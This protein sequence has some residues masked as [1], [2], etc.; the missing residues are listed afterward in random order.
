MSLWSERVHQIF[1]SIS[2]TFDRTN[3]PIS[4]GSSKLKFIDNYRDRTSTPHADD[5]AI[6][7]KL[8]PSP[9]GKRLWRDCEFTN[10]LHSRHKHTWTLRVI[11]YVDPDITPCPLY[12]AANV[13]LK[14]DTN[15]FIEQISLSPTSHNS[16]PLLTATNIDVLRQQD[17]NG[18]ATTVYR[19]SALRVPDTC[20]SAFDLKLF[21]TY[22]KRIEDD[23][24][25]CLCKP[26][27][28][29]RL[30]LFDEVQKRF[31]DDDDSGDVVFAFDN[32][33]VIRA[34]KW[35][36]ETRVPYFKRLFASGMREAETQRIEIKDA[37]PD[38]FRKML[39]FVNCAQLPD[40]VET[41]AADL[42]PIADKYDIQE[43]KDV[44]A[45]VFAMN[46]ETDNV[47]MTLILADLYR[48]ADL[49]NVCFEMMTR[50]KEEV[51]EKGMEPLLQHPQLLMEFLW[52]KE[53]QPKA[54]K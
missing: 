22:R 4:I 8:E 31:D 54:G 47:A 5:V 30:K 11:W 37:D 32:D 7:V 23:P 12:L 16:D 44:C 49:K 29:Y 41:S 39:R 15:T 27:P 17:T 46:L 50:R 51:G 3:L 34:H 38:T 45:A 52:W 9:S 42:L 36:L 20:E 21:I 2:V 6:P 14:S 53:K 48:C 35:M 18:Y 24:E 28:N 10:R 19:V 43:L 33:V 13:T 1:Q 40:D 26:L 25:D